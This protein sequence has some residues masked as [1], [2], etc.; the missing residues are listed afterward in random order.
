MQFTV[1]KGVKYDML[2]VTTGI[3]QGSILGPILFTLFT[4]ALP[5]EIT[6]GSLFMYADDTSI[7]CIGGSADAAIASLNRALHE[8]YR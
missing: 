8:V 7:F 3:T 6:M 5:A 2:P 1:P 4:T